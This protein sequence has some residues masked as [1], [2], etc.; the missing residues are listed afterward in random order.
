MKKKKRGFWCLHA[1]VS[2]SALQFNDEKLIPKKT[3]QPI[4]GGLCAL[5]FR[6][7]ESRESKKN[8]REK[9]NDGL[10]AAWNSGREGTKSGCL[11]SSRVPRD[12]LASYF[13]PGFFFFFLLNF[14]D[15]HRRKRGNALEEIYILQNTNCQL[16]ACHKADLERTCAHIEIQTGKTNFSRELVNQVFIVQHHITIN[17]IW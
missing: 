15:R 8:P 14:H 7:S 17:I 16:W 12:A 10:Q 1:F 5:P 2:W 9:K 3:E 4:K 6:W 11:L 13:F